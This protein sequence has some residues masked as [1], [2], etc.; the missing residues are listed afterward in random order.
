MRTFIGDLIECGSEETLGMGERHSQSRIGADV[1]T[2]NRERESISKAFNTTNLDAFLASV[3]DD[4]VWMDHGGPPPTI[5]K[6]T[7]RSNYK[8]FFERGPFIPKMTISSDEIVVSGEW[9]FD[10]GTWRIIRTYR[11][12]AR[13]EVLESCYLMVWQRQPGNA[14][15]L[16]RFIWNGSPVPLKSP[17]NGKESKEDK[18][19]KRKVDRDDKLA[20]RK[21]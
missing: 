10:R 19:K 17:S 13:R 16:A 4:V 21:S 6:E 8:E 18:R 2:I 14:W 20:P 7:V 1:E 12:A 11:R 9:A 15:K 3:A 5:G